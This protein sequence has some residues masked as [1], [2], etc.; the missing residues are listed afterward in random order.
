MRPNGIFQSVD[1]GP[2]CTGRQPALQPQKYEPDDRDQD[3]AVKNDAGV[4]GSEIARRDHLV[5][6]DAG[7][8]PE[9]AGWAEDSREQ[10]VEAAFERQQADSG[11]TEAGKADLELERTV[12]PAD[13]G[14]GRLPEEHMD[15]EII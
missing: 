11:K 12:G 2:T 10:H 8:A 5:D 3:V 7:G 9:E 1:R 4:A 6:V 14:R 15:D 13:E